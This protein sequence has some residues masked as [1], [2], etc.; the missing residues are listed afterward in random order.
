MADKKDRSR[1]TIQ[2]SETDPAHLEVIDI[3]NRQGRRSK[4]PYIVNA[5]LHY[6]SRAETPARQPVP[7]SVDVV[8]IEAVVRR[9]LGD[10]ERERVMPVKDG[11]P[12]P[13]RKP[14]KSI[15]SPEEMPFDDALDAIGA[16]GLDAIAG[17]LDAFRQK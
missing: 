7:Q 13:K 4:A 12:A 16:D 2:F 1:F 6:E 8:L 14:K 5:I 3:L 9:L 10:M 11:A 15:T 17:V